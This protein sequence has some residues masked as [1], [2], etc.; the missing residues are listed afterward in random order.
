LLFSRNG[1]GLRAPGDLRGAFSGL[2][3]DPGYAAALLALLAMVA[4]IAISAIV[5][6]W[7]ATISRG[8]WWAPFFGLWMSSSIFSYLFIKMIA[9][10]DWLWPALALCI[11]GR[12]AHSG[13]PLPLGRR[14]SITPAATFFH[15]AGVLAGTVPFVSAAYALYWGAAAVPG[16]RDRDSPSRIFPAGA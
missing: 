15:A 2:H 5:R 1:I 14:R 4:L 10:A 16:L 7:R 6:N 12:V 13:R 11:F 8:S 9:G 3:C